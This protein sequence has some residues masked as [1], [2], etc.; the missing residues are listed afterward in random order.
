MLWNYK[1]LTER[2]IPNSNPDIVT[3][4]H[5]KMK[6]YI[7]RCCK[8]RRQKCDQERNR[9]DSEIWRPY[10]RNATHVECKNKMIPLIIVVKGTISKSFRKYMCNVPGKQEIKELQKQPYCALHTV[11]GNYWCTAQNIWHWE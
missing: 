10:L 6:I 2:T 11:F 3:R 8:Y 9:E 7:K 1:V 4:D 5:K